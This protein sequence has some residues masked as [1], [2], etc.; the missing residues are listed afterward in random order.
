MTVFQNKQRGGIWSYDFWRNSWRYAGYCIDPKTGKPVTTKTAAKAIERAEITKAEESGARPQR[1]DGRYALAEAQAALLKRVI[2]KRRKKKHIANIR[3]WGDDILR[4]FGPEK[5]FAELTQADV[6]GYIVAVFS[7]TVKRWAGG[8]RSPTKADYGNPALWRD[9]GRLRSKRQGNNYAKH[10]RKMLGVAAKVKDPVTRRPVL[11][12]DPPLEIELERVPKRKPR[13]MPDDEL[14]ARMESLP[15]WRQD[16]AELARRYGL[17]AEETYRV[18][19]R[20]VEGAARPV[21]FFRG[22]EAK[23]GHDEYAQSGPEGWALVNRLRRQAKARGTTYLLTWPG[24]LDGVHWY[25]VWRAGGKVPDAAW[26]PLRGPGSSWKKSAKRAGIDQPHRFHDVR[27][28]AITAV[29]KVS[30][31]AAKGFARHQA[32]ATTDLYIGVADD[33]VAAAAAEAMPRRAKS[34]RK[35]RLRAVR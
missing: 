21:I 25:P 11:D 22:E 28:R 35:P 10:F 24:P 3:L 15:P 16:Q 34:A 26:Q 8:K 14:E 20:H 19:L 17:R 9:T 13:P 33:E 2:E 18:E 1:G 30:R 12:Q 7:E 29:S 23:S 27:A 5:P 6:D 4:H 32:S 31:S